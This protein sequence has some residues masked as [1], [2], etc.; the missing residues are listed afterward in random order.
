MPVR[1]CLIRAAPS[2][3][4]FSHGCLPY[5]TLTDPMRVVRTTLML[6]PPG[7]QPYPALPK[8]SQRNLTQLTNL[9]KPNPIYSS[10][11]TS[12]TSTDVSLPNLT[13]LFSLSLTT[14]RNPKP[15]HFSCQNL[16]KPWMKWELSLETPSASCKDASCQSPRWRA[17][18]HRLVANYNLKSARKKIKYKK[19]VLAANCKMKELAT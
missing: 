16:Y 2:D 1:K 18:E 8:L 17:G 7:P 4:T 19:N 11:I 14:E 12:R 15:I 3:Q 5:V 13:L 9:L 6:T 10:S